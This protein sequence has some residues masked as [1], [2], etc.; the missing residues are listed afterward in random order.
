MQYKVYGIADRETKEIKYI[1]FSSNENLL[2]RLGNHLSQIKKRS[3]RRDEWLLT[4]DDA[5]IMITLFESNSRSEALKKEKEFIKKFLDEGYDLLNE[6]CNYNRRWKIA[7]KTVYQYD[8]NG[9][10]I[11]EYKT[12]GEAQSYSNNFFKSKCISA[13]C[14]FSKRTHKNFFWSFEKRE[15]YFVPR[16]ERT[17]EEYKS[18]YCYDL[19]DNFLK[20][21]RTAGEAAR[22]L[23]LRTGDIWKNCNKSEFRKSVNR[24]KKYKFSYIKGLRYSPS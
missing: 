3:T 13:C 4:L 21:Y 24:V 6:Q 8:L 14:N 22:D 1:G 2:I 10:Y 17:Y 7:L 9:N 15:K 12:A 18:V 11:K 5:P 16:K 20:E 19:N 23:N